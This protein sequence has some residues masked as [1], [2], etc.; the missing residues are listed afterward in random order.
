VPLDNF[1]RNI[2]LYFDFVAH[3]VKVLLVFK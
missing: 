2:D 3:L 1:G